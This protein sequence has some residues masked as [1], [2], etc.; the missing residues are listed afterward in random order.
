MDEAEAAVGVDGDDDRDD[1]PFH[2]LGGGACVELLAELHDVDLRLTERGADWRC[3]SSFAGFDL[4]LD[5]AGNFL[6]SCHVRFLRKQLPTPGYELSAVYS[7][8]YFGVGAAAFTCNR[9]PPGG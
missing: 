8:F 7:L 4:K 2:L 5:V 9:S 3:R 1:Q 6:R